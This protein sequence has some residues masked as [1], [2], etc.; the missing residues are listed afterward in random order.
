MIG[1]E[2]K[3]G[4]LIESDNMRY[5]K[6]G[7]LHMSKSGETSVCDGRMTETPIANDLASVLPDQYDI[8]P[9]TVVPEPTDAKGVVYF[10]D[11]DGSKHSNSCNFCPNKKR[12]KLIMCDFCPNSCHMRCARPKIHRIPKDGVQ[13]RCAS[14]MTQAAV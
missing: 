5:V 7:D 14:C 10:N 2:G 6:P 3:G 1:E 11:T 4:Y 9:G 8:A 13:W 12:G